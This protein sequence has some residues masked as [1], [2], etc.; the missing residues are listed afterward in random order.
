M[1]KTKAG[2]CVVAVQNFW[3]NY[4]KGLT[5][6]R[7][8]I[9][10]GI[11]PDVSDV[12]Y[13]VGRGRGGPALLSPVR[14]GTQIQVRD[15]AYARAVL[16]LRAPWQRSRPPAAGKGIPADPGRPCGTRSL[17]AKRRGWPDGVQVLSHR[18]LRALER[19]RSSAVPRRS[20]ETPGLRNDE[21]RRLVRRAALQLGQ[22]GIR[23]AVGVPERVHPRRRARVVRTRSTGRA[24]PGGRG[25][26]SRV[27]RVRRG[28]QP[29]CALH[30]PRRRLLP[31][32]LS[33]NGQG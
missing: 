15:V 8:G 28:R 32:G 18:F 30:G 14:G 22:P 19:G 2:A 17:R 21:F 7:K 9:G 16:R 20:E 6:G 23:H 33:R 1:S 3:Q 13:R 10:V 26:L 4:P 12:D 25:H 11:C 27:I 29:V 24:P 31:A 5:L